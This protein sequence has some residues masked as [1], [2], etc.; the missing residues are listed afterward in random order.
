MV[1]PADA[2]Q[3]MGVEGGHPRHIGEGQPLDLGEKFGRCAHVGRF[4]PFAA[5]FLRCKVGAV[6]LDHGDIDRQGPGDLAQFIIFRI[7][8]GAGK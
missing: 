7:G 4:I 6:G 8:Q 1:D 3:A 2:E 5:P